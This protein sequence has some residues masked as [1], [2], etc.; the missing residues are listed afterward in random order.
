[1]ALN[2]VDEKDTILHR[3]ITILPVPAFGY[4]PETSTYIG[5]VSLF[6]LDLFD[7]SIT[8]TSN[9]KVEFNY[10]WKKQYITDLGWEAYTRKE[11]YYLKGRLT[12][13]RY[14]DLYYGLGENTSEKDEISFDSRRFVFDGCFLKALHPN[15][16]MGIVLRHL[17]YH[18]LH[19]SPDSFPQ[20]PELESHTN[21]GIGIRLMIDK[22]NHLLN[23]THGIYGDINYTVNNSPAAYYHKIGFDGRYYHTFNEMHTVAARLLGAFTF[24]DAP[25]YDLALLG[26]DNQA[27]GYYLG[28]FRDKNLVSLQSEYR[29]TLYRRW[30]Y[31]FFGGTSK[32]FHDL[33][34]TNLKNLKWNYGCGVRFMIDRKERTNLRIDYAFGNEGVSGLYIS[35]GEAF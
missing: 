8:R 9:A 26:G 7:D 16:F 15:I 21:S 23:T 28:R 3:Q 35:F 31:A 4:S 2:I 18:L 34:T 11:Q 1:M 22:R 33:S 20:F 14:P 30:G 12:F 19:Y 25:F 29:G 17:Q 27:R 13:S 5:V 32:L 10:T 6:T 24:N